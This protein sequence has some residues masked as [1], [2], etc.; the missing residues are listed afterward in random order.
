MNTTIPA[1]PGNIYLCGYSL[2]KPKVNK[3]AAI[4]MKNKIAKAS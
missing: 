4:T 3:P 1:T 2:F